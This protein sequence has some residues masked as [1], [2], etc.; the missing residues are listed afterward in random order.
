MV[1]DRNKQIMDFHTNIA[2]SEKRGIQI[3]ER[4]AAEKTAVKLLSKGL[5]INDICDIT[6][7]SEEE[8]KALKNQ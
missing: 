8:I 4:K 6:N 2:A 1:E 3:G 7:I 5:G